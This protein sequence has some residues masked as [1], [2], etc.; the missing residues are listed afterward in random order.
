MVDQDF[1]TVLDI[2]AIIW[3]K[4]DYS[5]NNHHY[6]T[7]LPKLSELLIKL[8]R[9]NTRILMRSTLLGEMVNEFPY[10]L[11]P[12]ELW[13]SSAQV[14]SFLGNIGSI[15]INYNDSTVDG[16]TSFP[17]QVKSYFSN[18]V[19]TEVNYLLT[20]I[21]TKFNK[22]NTFFS[23]SSLFNCTDSL[24][25]TI[26]CQKKVHRTIIA[27]KEDILENFL[28][29]FHLIFKHSQKHDK[30][31]HKTREAWN[32]TDEKNDFES[33]LSCYDGDS[34]GS[35]ELLD[36]RYNKL[37]GNKYYYSYDSIN[38]VY[39]VFRMT[40][41]N[42]YHAYDMYDIERVPQEVKE[43]FHIWKY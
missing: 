25:T 20:E 19:K 42:I 41:N 38:E 8:E 13:A 2:S 7:F 30:A 29:S 16:I 11:L 23:F 6:Y 34:T 5:E 14:Y 4:E 32:N 1:N 36:T 3:D 15:I 40:N 9:S 37:F 10:S 12:N 35:Q 31:E 26:N 43:H 24:Q 28:S 21:H 33:Q 22:Q 18:N 27:D 39:V 17:N